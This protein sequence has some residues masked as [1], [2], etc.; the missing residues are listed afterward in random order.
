VLAAST[1]EIMSVESGSPAARSGVRD[2]DLVLGLGVHD[3]ASVDELVRVL[4]SVTPGETI[5]LRLVR[6]GQLTVVPV[7]PLEK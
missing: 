7:T 3:V 5:P 2:G 1:V 6:R 4:R